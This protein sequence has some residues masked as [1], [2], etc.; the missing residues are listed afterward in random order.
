MHAL[1]IGV[2]L[3]LLVA[4]RGTPGSVSAEAAKRGGADRGS[5]SSY[6]ADHYDDDDDDCN[7]LDQTQDEGDLAEARRLFRLVACMHAPIDEAEQREEDPEDE[8]DHGAT[9]GARIDT[10]VPGLLDDDDGLLALRLY[11]G[12]NGHGLLERGGRGGKSVGL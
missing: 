1:R 4:H 12:L 6:S 5:N 7:Y 3:L 8:H 11:Y 9:V 2:A 10:G